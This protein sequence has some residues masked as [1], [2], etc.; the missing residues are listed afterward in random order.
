ML[1]PEL[2]VRNVGYI[3]ILYEYLAACSG[4]RPRRF[5]YNFI[6]PHGGL[7]GRAPAKVAGIGIEGEDKRL[8]L[9]GSSVDKK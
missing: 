8:K 9:L 2:K 3:F 6:R 5:D 4:A 7:D 1:N